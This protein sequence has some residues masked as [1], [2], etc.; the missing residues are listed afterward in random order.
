MQGD[1]ESGLREKIWLCIITIGLIMR[2]PAVHRDDTALAVIQNGTFK[3]A[4]GLHGG[5]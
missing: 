5:G 1:S 2:D 3:R 4:A